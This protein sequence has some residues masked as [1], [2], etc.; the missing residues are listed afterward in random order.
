MTDWDQLREV[1]DQLSPPAFESLVTTADKQRARRA[2]I[3]AATTALSVLTALGLGLGLVNDD[4]DGVVQ[5]VKDPSHSVTTEEETLPDGVLALPES[6]AGAD[7]AT[8]AAGRYRVPL[9]DTVSF[10]VDLPSES[11]AHDGGL[12]IA[13]GGVVLKTVIADEEYGVPHDPC[14]A[15][16]LDPVGAE[17][18]DLVR[19]IHNRPVYHASRPEPTQI[20]GAKGTYLEVEI[21][22]AFDASRCANGEVQSPGIPATSVGWEPSSR[23]RYWILDVDGQRVVVAQECS[24]AAD[25]FGQAATIARSITFTPTP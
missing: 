4:E 25:E 24:C 22:R 1:G 19:A 6:D 9:S 7:F 8:L 15:Q 5:P 23:G 21:P 2:R 11:Y 18:D 10:D 17:V 16:A 20:G 13:T 12:F 3:I 14:T